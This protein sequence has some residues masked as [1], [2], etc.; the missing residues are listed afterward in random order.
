MLRPLA[1]L[2]LVSLAVA[3]SPQASDPRAAVVA[4]LDGEPIRAQE[5]LDQMA[6]EGLARPGPDT[7]RRT[8]D[9]LIDRRL[10]RRAAERRGIRVTEEE[11]VRALERL[12]A[13]YPEGTFAETLAS[14]NLEEDEVRARLTESL[15][16]QRLFVEEVVARV[17]V[18]DEEI[19]AWLEENGASLERPEQVRAAQIVV[20]TEEEAQRLREELENGA[21]FEELARAHSLSPDARRGGDLGFFARGEMPPPFDEVCFALAPGQISD[22]VS[23]SYGFHIFKLLERRAA[24]MPDP[25]RMRV[26]AERV[27]RREKEMAAQEAFI[28]SLRQAAEIRIDEAALARLLGNP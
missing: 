20:K 11:T 16:L 21:S 7:L 6:L 9:E 2:L 17:A 19:N 10:L 8:L 24:E 5:I 1:L 4:T 14:Q 3:C 22:V 23:S 26:E 28:A 25:A 15:L 27:L 13:D 18:T 12:K